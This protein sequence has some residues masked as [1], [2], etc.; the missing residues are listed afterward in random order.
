MKKI[1]M[2]ALLST[3]VFNL[4]SWGQGMLTFFSQD[5][6]KFWVIINGEK[7]NMQAQYNVKDIPVTFQWGKVTIKFE[8]N[9]IPDINKTV[10][11]VDVDNNWCHVKY[12]IKKDKK[13]KYVMNNLDATFDVIT[14]TTTTTTNSTTTSTT[15][16]PTE[17]VPVN[18]TVTTTVPQGTQTQTT[19]TQNVN[20][21]Q[22]TNMNPTGV[23]TTVTDPVTGETITLGANINITGVNTTGVSTTTTTTS[24]TTTGTTNTTIQNKPPVTT[25]TQTINNQPDHYVMPGYNG[26]VGCPWPMKENDFAEAKASVAS[27]S[28]EDSK[29]TIAKQVTSSNCLLCSQVKEMMSTFSFEDTKLEFAKFAY[30]YVYDL[31]NYYKL[32]DAF[33]F[34]STI[35]E[36]NQ[37]VNSKKK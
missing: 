11:V 7:K 32:N 19:N 36:L 31:N 37:Y 30:D 2:I 29:L 22:T 3:L 15:T 33:T 16:Q 10:Q 21:S 1:L 28:F 20:F 17:N 8:D 14:T 24:S 26:K 23:T 27:K 35:D 18:T 13:G 6:Q 5:G 9:K 34:E 4:S 12:M 25:N